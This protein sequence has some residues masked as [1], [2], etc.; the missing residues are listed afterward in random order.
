MNRIYVIERAINGRE[1]LTSISTTTTKKKYLFD[2]TFP[3]REKEGRVYNLIAISTCSSRL[4]MWIAIISESKCGIFFKSTFKAGYENYEKWREG[5][6]EVHNRIKQVFNF[7]LAWVFSRTETSSSD[8]GGAA[9]KATRTP[10]RY[11][12]KTNELPLLEF[13]STREIW[14]NDS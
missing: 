8:A 9:C 2:R 13:P 7:L 10:P 5:V 14:K 6:D 11:P 1:K 12:Q 4:K 3:R